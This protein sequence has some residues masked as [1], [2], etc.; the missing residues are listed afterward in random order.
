MLSESFRLML[1]E[2]N[3]KQSHPDGK[4]SVRRKGILITHWRGQGDGCRRTA[5]KRCADVALVLS[6]LRADQAAAPVYRFL[7][8]Q[9]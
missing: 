7:I 2:N 6:C 5:K 3:E 9:Q 4:L 1:G 8:Y